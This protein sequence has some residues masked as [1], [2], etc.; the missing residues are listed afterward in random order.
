MIL[1]LL[2]DDSPANAHNYGK[3]FVDGKYLA[4]TLE[5]KDRYLEAGGEKIDGETAIPRGRYSVTRTFSNRFKRVMVLV[6]GVPGF[7]GVRIH[8]GNTEANTEGCPMLG[9]A[10][11]GTG[12]ANCAGVNERLDN[13]VEAALNRGEDVWLEVK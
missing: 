7:V 12:I 10:R 3:F 13:A 2:R 1:E 11:I 4:E 6:N 9:A 8:G 5:D